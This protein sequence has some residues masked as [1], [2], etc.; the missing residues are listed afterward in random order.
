MHSYSK[1]LLATYC[2]PV[3]VPGMEGS[4]D[5][6]TLLLPSGNSQSRGRNRHTH[7]LTIYPVTLYLFGQPVL[8]S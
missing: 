1:H 6:L 3:P 5:E 2:M 8:P 7:V 4:S